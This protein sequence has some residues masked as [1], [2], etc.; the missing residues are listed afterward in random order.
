MGVVCRIG[1]FDLSWKGGP[2]DQD[3]PGGL[4]CG[5][6]TD[7]PS[8]VHFKGL[9]KAKEQLITDEER[10]ALTAAKEAAKEAAR[11]AEEE[12]AKVAHLAAVSAAMSTG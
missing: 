6:G 7:V 5:I 11:L 4:V 9:T 3:R 8:A 1:G 10:A 2:V 12:A